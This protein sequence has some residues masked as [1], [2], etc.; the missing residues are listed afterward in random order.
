MS[1]PEGMVYE[2]L[3][4]TDQV[5]WHP[6]KKELTDYQQFTIKMVAAAI[7]WLRDTNTKIDIN[8]ITVDDLIEIG[9]NTK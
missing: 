8:T 4:L 3:C 1:M 2:E 5:V 9:R 6:K 7:D